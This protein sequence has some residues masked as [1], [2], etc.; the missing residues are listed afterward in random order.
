MSLMPRSLGLLC[1]SY[2]DHIPSLE[3]DNI[4]LMRRSIHESMWSCSRMRKAAPGVSAKYKRI[5]CG[6]IQVGEILNT[7]VGTMKRVLDTSN[8][9]D[10]LAVC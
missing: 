7:K 4:D 10:R 1:R 2:V 3:A 8:K 9:Y 6:A 5:T